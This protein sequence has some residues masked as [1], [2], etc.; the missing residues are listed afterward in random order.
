MVT[1]NGSS[2]LTVRGLNLEWCSL[3]LLV[4]LMIIKWHWVIICWCITMISDEPTKACVSAM[5]LLLITTLG[6]NQGIFKYNFEY[7]N[8][9]L[10]QRNYIYCVS[11]IIDGVFDLAIFIKIAKLNEHHLYCR[12]R[13]LSIQ[14]SKLPKSCQNLKILP[15][16]FLSKSS[17]FWL[18]NNSVYTVWHKYT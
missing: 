5:R 10:F 17:N 12:N 3:L 2:P 8:I 4:C 13:F 15:I 16:A 18:A 1:S 6:L 11:I 7:L 9:N 14:Y